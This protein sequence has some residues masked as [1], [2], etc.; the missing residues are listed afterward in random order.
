MT[1]RTAFDAVADVVVVGAGS[2]GCA[3]A[4]RLSEDPSVRVLLLEA[5]G[6]DGTPLFAVPGGQV[7]VRDWNR[8][9]W[10]YACAADPTRGGRA[11]EWRRG[12]ILGGSS[13]INGLI[14]ALG[15]PSDYDAWARAGLPGWGW[16]GVAPWFRRVE[17]YADESPV[18]RGREGPVAV[19][20]FRS[21]HPLMPD[22][23]ASF[24]TE[25]VPVVD[26]INAAAGAAVG[27]VQTNQRRGLR[28]SASAAYL[29][30]ARGRTTL[31]VWTDCRAD[32][33]LFEGGRA[34]GLALRRGDR[35]AR[36]AA[37][38]E[39]VLCAGAIASPLLLMRSGIGPGG[40]L[41]SLGIPLLVDAPDVGRHLQ[42]H[43]ELYVEYEVDV[44][45][46]TRHRQWLTMAGI[47]LQW[48]LSR[49]GPATSPG[50]HLLGYAHSGRTPEGPPD[51]LLFAGPWGRLEDALAFTRGTPVFSLS[52]SVAR[53]RSR[54]E[55]RPS[56]PHLEDPPHIEPNLL[57]DAEDV[58]TLMDG[59]RL[60][61]RIARA[62]PFARHVRRRLAPAV[63]LGDDAALERFVRDDASI[64]YHA[65]GTCRMGADGAAVLDG[66]L[67]V[68]G[69]QGLR[70]ADTS[71]IPAIP[72]GNLNA[73]AIMIGERAA[74]FVRRA[75]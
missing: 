18:E 35:Q 69:V 26:D 66:E 15:L 60:V 13:T 17:R 43:P 75:A 48:A 5:G 67:R 58:R 10:R 73:P 1:E 23:L 4:A 72:S 34:S 49:R 47:G 31:E 42:E 19:E 54:G 39:I 20:Q 3:V 11:D 41:Q 24:A 57:A 22:L 40:L 61:D 28:Q 25:G 33:V 14:W 29:G 21:P 63:D 36:V 74:D 8:Y 45:T 6:R 38:K 46:Y 2:A 51:L 9:A 62:A 59:V 56:G 32:R 44:P 50:S 71:V 52:P 12:R 64:C 55:I 30:A 27:V 68:R 65:C 37:R 70:V 7:L 16:S 53:P